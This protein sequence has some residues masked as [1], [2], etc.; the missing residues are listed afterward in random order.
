MTGPGRELESG[1]IEVS[2]RSDGYFADG[3]AG[4]GH[5]NK[6]VRSEQDSEG[7]VVLHSSPSSSPTAGEAASVQTGLAYPQPQG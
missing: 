5:D 6:A 1:R 3:E 4:A 7:D 2:M